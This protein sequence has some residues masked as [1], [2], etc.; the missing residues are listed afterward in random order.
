MK[1]WIWLAMVIAL[2]IPVTAF[3]TGGGSKYAVC[4]ATADHTYPYAHY[5]YLEVGNLNGHFYGGNPDY[6]RHGAWKLS[7]WHWFYI[8]D[9]VTVLGDEDCDGEKDYEPCDET[10]PIYG[11]WSDWYYEDEMLIRSRT[12]TY[13]DAYDSE[14]VCGRDIEYEHEEYASCEGDYIAGPW[15]EWVADGT[16]QTRSRELFD[17]IS[18]E[19][20]GY[21]TET[22]C[23]PIYDVFYWD[24]GNCSIRQRGG[25]IMGQTRPFHYDQNAYCGCGYA[26]DE[27]WEGFWVNNCQ[28]EYKFWN[29]LPKYCGFQSCE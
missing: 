1:K 5:E 7:G 12:V 17:P 16:K 24:D 23:N 19:I 13:V 26:H 8:Q 4:H 25:P 27:G 28:S 15:G 20:C 3:A 6:P 11:E 14:I 2:A 29:E 18:E 10:T 9:F 22:K 21:E